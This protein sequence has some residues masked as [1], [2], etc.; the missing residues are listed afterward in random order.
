MRLPAVVARTPG[1]R[2]L[3]PAGTRLSVLTALTALTALTM[4]GCSSM[5]SLNPVDWFSSTPVGVKPA[6]LPALSNPQPVRTLWQTNVGSSGIFIFSPALAGDSVYVAARDGSITRLEAASGKIIWKAAAGAQLSGGVGTDGKL[7]AVGSDKG[8][9]IVLDAANGS[10]RWRARVSS[11]MLAAPKVAGGTV[12]AR[13]ADS[14]IFAF[15]AADGKRRW[16]YQRAASSLI[17]RSPA[18]ITVGGGNVYAGFAG[19]KLV[20][21]VLETGALRWEATVSQPKGSTELERVSDVSGDPALLGR[22]ICAASYQ[23]RAACFDLQSG[24]Q[25]WA[26]EMST[27]NGMS[28]DARYGYVSDDRG[29]V[30]SLDRSNGRSVWK[31]DRLTYRELSQPMPLGNEIV[32]GDLQGFVHFLAR[33]SGAF[34]A[35][36]ATDGSKIRAAPLKL[37]NGVLIQTL[38]G[39]LFALSL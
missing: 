39:G 1:P 21:L 36:S 32:V 6:E 14:R 20:A 22:E 18:G 33:D 31:Q 15:D 26:R 30:N 3:R 7:V 9:L 25:V 5:P 35:R 16:V 8:E 13:T 23:G 37:P 34:V 2:M 4:A 28:I 10:L 19:G 27:L 24:N 12:L 11:E 29:A 17:V 38:N